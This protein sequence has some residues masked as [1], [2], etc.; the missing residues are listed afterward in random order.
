MDF[1]TFKQFIYTLN[2]RDYHTNSKGEKCQDNDVIRIHLD[3]SSH[4]SFNY[5]ELGWYDYMAKDDTWKILEIT[6]NKSI[7]NSKITD[8]QYNDKFNILE[9]WIDEKPDCT[10]EE[11]QN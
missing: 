11:Y 9:V 2:I 5:I 3:S 6:L 4:D 10:I 8:I 1:I 7:L